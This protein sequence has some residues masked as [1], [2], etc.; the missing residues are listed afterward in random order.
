MVGFKRRRVDELKGVPGL[1]R[2]GLSRTMS[3]RIK[4]H[5]SGEEGY[6]VL[7]RLRVDAA[8]SNVVSE[9]GGVL[10]VKAVRISDPDRGSSAGGWRRRAG[11]WGGTIRS[12]T[13]STSTVADIPGI[14]P[15]VLALAARTP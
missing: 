5:L 9:A 13:C 15:A 3:S 7:P 12:A 4:E 8:G 14:C 2:C 1:R 11:R 10:L 6:R